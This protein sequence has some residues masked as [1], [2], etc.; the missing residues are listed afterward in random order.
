MVQNLLLLHFAK[1]LYLEF[2]VLPSSG[3]GAR[4]DSSLARQSLLW[5]IYCATPT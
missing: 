1:L 4:Q 3:H 5:G 2:R